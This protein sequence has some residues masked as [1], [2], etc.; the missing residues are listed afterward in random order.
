M[1]AAQAESVY[2]ALRVVG[3]PVTLPPRRHEA[4]LFL[5]TCRKDRGTVL[6]MKSL[7]ES[8][9]INSDSTMC[10]LCLRLFEDCLFMHWNSFEF[11]DQIQIRIF[12]CS[13]VDLCRAALPSMPIRTKLAKLISE[14]GKRQY[15]Q[16]WDSFVADLLGSWSVP[17]FSLKAQVSFST[18]IADGDLCTDYVCQVCAMGLE[19]LVED[20]VDSNFNEGLPAKRRNDILVELKSKDL[21]PILDLS[22]GI[23]SQY[24]G[25][26]A[27]L[28]SGAGPE[29]TEAIAAMNTVLGMLAPLALLAKP[30]EMTDPLR[31]YADVTVLLLNV[32]PLKDRAL[33]LLGRVGRVG[34]LLSREALGSLLQS[35]PPVL[36]KIFGSLPGHSIMDGHLYYGSSAGRVVVDGL[37]KFDYSKRLIEVA[38]VI[39]ASNLELLEDRHD[40]DS[41]DRQ[42]V[43]N[44]Q[45]E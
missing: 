1:S 36:G 43:G 15:P 18:I 38:T 31:N 34:H 44:L 29:L 21:S 22:Y 17:H 27:T 11:A 30:S 32:E 28:P 25:H 41:V 14:L 23:L 37:D 6:I 4:T 10:F 35:L 45:V 26:I 13:L 24:Y 20:C 42:Q 3:D 19:F 12:A 7:L 9:Q 16:L 8:P 5:E 2:M 39:L 40:S 33:E